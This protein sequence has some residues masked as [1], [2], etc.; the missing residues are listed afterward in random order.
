MYL[1]GCY[2][3]STVHDNNIFKIKSQ[4]RA[5]CV[6][7]CMCATEKEVCKR[8]YLM[9]HCPCVSVVP[10]RVFADKT[11]ACHIE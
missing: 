3:L 2:L 8:K 4:K 1:C 6:C 11:R 9:K 5:G 10:L 7:E